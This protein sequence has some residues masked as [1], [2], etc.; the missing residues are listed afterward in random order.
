MAFYTLNCQSLTLM[1]ILWDL[2]RSDRENGLLLKWCKSY[3]KVAQFS[4]IWPLFSWFQHQQ[5][6]WLLAHKSMKLINVETRKVKI[7]EEI[8]FKKQCKSKKI[9]FRI[10]NIEI[11]LDDA[12]ISI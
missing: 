7:N 2:Q 9:V 11:L 6:K 1:A 8:K 4:T 10:C 5:V 12:F 3:L